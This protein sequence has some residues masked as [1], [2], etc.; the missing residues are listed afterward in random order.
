MNSRRRPHCLRLHPL[1]HVNTNTAVPGPPGHL[2]GTVRKVALGTEC[3]RQSAV[4]IWRHLPCGLLSVRD[5]SVHTPGSYNF[6]FYFWKTQGKKRLR[7]QAHPT[8]QAFWTIFFK[9][10]RQPHP[11]LSDLGH[12][13]GSQQILKADTST[14]V[15]QVTGLVP[16]SSS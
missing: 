4:Q 8:W 16:H 12:R 11:S 10:G 2:A 15:G 6:C 9:Q 7:Y 3:S 1:C 5:R 14:W 13:G